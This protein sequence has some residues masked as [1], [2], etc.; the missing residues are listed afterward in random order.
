MESFLRDVSSLDES[1]RHVLEDVLGRSLHP[2]QTL[3][4]SVAETATAPP[5]QSED[6]C[7]QQSLEDW[8]SVYDGLSPQQIESIERVA[9]T[10]ANLSRY[11]P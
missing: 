11:L 10:R 3:I 8:T 5:S 9:K 1:Q 6:P 2:N 7:E 4:I